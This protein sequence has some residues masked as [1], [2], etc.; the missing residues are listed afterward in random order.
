MRAC[1]AA[2]GILGIFC[3]GGCSDAINP[4]APSPVSAVPF[5]SSR[6]DA[7]LPEAGEA[8][9][10]LT[11]TSTVA[12]GERAGRPKKDKKLKEEKKAERRER[13]R[14]KDDAKDKTRKRDPSN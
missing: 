11:L 6:V 1:Y 8:V 14:A 13:R 5:V 10:G 12:D 4:V 3:A 7:V 2:V 9:T